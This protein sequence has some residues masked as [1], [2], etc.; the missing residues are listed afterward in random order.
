MLFGS[1]S[2]RLESQLKATAVVLDVQAEFVHMPNIVVVSFGDSDTRTSRTHFIKVSGVLQLGR[3]HTVHK[4]Y[5]NVVH[6][7]VGVEEA[8]A[9]LNQIIKAKPIFGTLS[10]TILAAL[11]TGLICPMAFGGSFVDMLVAGG[12][13]ALLSYLQFGIASKNAMYSNVFEISVAIIMSFIARGLASIPSQIFCYSAI[14]SAGIVLVLPGYMI[15]CSA[16]EL[17]SKNIV[18]GSVKLTFA[19]VYSLFLGFG[20][21]IGSDLYLLLDSNARNAQVMA[22][23]D[24][25]Q[26]VINGRFAASNDSVITNFAGSFTFTNG[27]S[28]SSP[29]NTID[30]C[31]R[32]PNWPWYL[33]PFPIWSLAILV[34]AFSICSSASNG[35]PFRSRQL[36]VMTLISCAS[37]AAN[38]AA[39][40][41]IFNR[42]D[43]VSAI[44][45]FVAGLLGNLYSRVTKTGTSFTSMVT[46]VLFLVPAGIAATG[47]LSQNYRGVDGDQY[48]NGL[49]IGLRTVQVA[50]GITVGLFASSLLIYSFG[51]TKR[52]AIFA[53]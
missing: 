26:V 12:E 8:T 42:S 21:T 51:R 5:R 15:L 45:A 3:L 2:H 33:Q 1:P 44:G 30:G 40:H 19:I 16:L 47:G 7:D 4:I 28:L 24:M 41:L 53:F 31:Y 22:S 34:P 27:T 39:N 46:G 35:Q 52:G 48:S 43:V 38:T 9:Q 29:P 23:E 37:F 20:L 17:A 50:I 25:N 13:G 11:C 14:S 36:P 6:D 32:D 49:I 10:K 18:T